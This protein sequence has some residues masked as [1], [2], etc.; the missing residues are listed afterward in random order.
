MSEIL[1]NTRE[2]EKRMFQEWE[3]AKALA[4]KLGANIKNEIGDCCDVIF[5]SKEAVEAFMEARGIKRA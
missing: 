2:A 5:P 4:I 3:D 1:Y